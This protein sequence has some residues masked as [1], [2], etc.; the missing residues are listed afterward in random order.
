MTHTIHKISAEDAIAFVCEATWGF[1]EVAPDG[2]FTWVNP[3]FCK[4]L[5][6][7]P[8]LIIGTSYIDWT[9]PDDIDADIELARKVKDGEIPSYTFVKRYV[10]RGSTPKNPRL[11]WGMLSV[12]GK[13]DQGKFLSY[14][15]QFQPYDVIQSNPRWPQRL[16]EVLVWT[17]T[18]WKSILTAVF[19]LLSLTWTGSEKLL[20]VLQKAKQAAD[21][22]DGALSPLPPGQSQQP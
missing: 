18:N 21:S 2:T 11:V 15:V 6:A 5:D 22:A 7:P 4:I 17:K 3:A 19:V 10:K 13:W 8:D 14:R 9:Y 16:T 12:A 1:A 20:E